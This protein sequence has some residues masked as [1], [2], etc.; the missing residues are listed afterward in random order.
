MLEEV[1]VSSPQELEEFVAT[2]SCEELEK[3]FE[4]AKGLFKDKI[5]VLD[6]AGTIVF[7]GDLHG[8]IATVYSL[9]ERLGLEEVLNHYKLVFL[10]DYVDRGPKQIEAL[11]LVL[12][13]KA[14]RPEEVIVLRGNHEPPRGLE[15]LPF[16]FP[17][18]LKLRY[19]DDWEI[20]YKSARKLFD[21]M[22][23]ALLIEEAVVAFHGGPPTVLIRRGCE[24]IGCLYGE[25]RGVVEEILWNEPANICSWDD[26]PETCWASNPKGMGY[27]WGP[28]ITRELLNKTGTK[29]LV[30]ADTPVDGV[31]LFH[32]NRG[33]SV[34][35]R[36]GVPFANKRAGL[37]APD[38]TKQR[39]YESPSSWAIL[40]P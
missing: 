3:M 23:L 30:R 38:F 36:L 27:L 40:I 13:L 14:R 31:K 17:Y 22:P 24:G 26:P 8:D 21:S 12:A 35:T 9:W 15:P 29:F 6:P 28:G 4:E 10:G 16:E 20:V 18:F 32:Y 37:W 25:A 11:L 5:E 2:L 7:H 39:W 34:F 19:K 1:P 33:V